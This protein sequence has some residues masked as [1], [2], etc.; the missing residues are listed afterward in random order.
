MPIEIQVRTESPALVVA[1]VV[2]VGVL[3]LADKGAALPPALRP[4]DAALGGA[5][6]KLIAKEEFK[7]KREQSLA[8]G[9]LGRIP[10]GKLVL[11]GLGERRKV[12]APE[13]RSFAARAA[14]AGNTEKAT[15][16]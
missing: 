6:S 10:G 9:T 2:V 5:L 8:M 4:L 14:R 11:L 16:V 3:Q 13:M 12:G 7:G 15:S 1:D